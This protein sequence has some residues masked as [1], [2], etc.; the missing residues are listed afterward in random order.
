MNICCKL[1]GLDRYEDLGLRPYV[2]IGSSRGACS[3]D[4]ALSRK[5]LECRRKSLRCGSGHI[6]LIASMAAPSGCPSPLRKESSP[7]NRIF[8]LQEGPFDLQGQRAAGSVTETTGGVRKGSPRGGSRYLF[9]RLGLAGPLQPL[10]PVRGP[11]SVPA[12]PASLQ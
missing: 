8:K 12:C 6:K 10:A 9:W 2:G 3:R 11:L 5:R 4:G 1:Q 7:A